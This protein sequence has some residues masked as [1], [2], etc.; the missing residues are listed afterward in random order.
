[1][2]IVSK[3]YHV[4]WCDWILLAQC[5]WSSSMLKHVS[6]PHSIL[7]LNSIPP[8]GYTTFFV[9]QLIIILVALPL[10]YYYDAAM[11]IHLQPFAG[12]C[13]FIYPEYIPRCRI[14]SHI[15]TLYLKTFWRTIRLFQND[16]T[17]LHATVMCEDSS[18]STFFT[19]TC[20]LFY[21]YYSHWMDVKWCLIVV[22]LC[23]FLMTNDVG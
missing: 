11:N 10:S 16:R 22:L 6:I 23:I 17:V 7:L 1:M 8:N 19:S 5:F 14:S 12:M 3:W 13:I 21:F 18:F 15:I 9:Y 20:Y 2:P 4:K